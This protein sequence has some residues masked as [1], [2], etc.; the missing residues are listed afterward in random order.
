MLVSSGADFNIVDV[1]G[2]TALHYSASQ[3][4]FFCVFTLVGIGSQVNLTDK[5][6]CTAL[7]LAA[8][9]DLEGKY[10]KEILYVFDFNCFFLFVVDALST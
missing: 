3:G 10:V 2:R 9:Y 4:H 7:H 5:E 8:A 1:I 6:G